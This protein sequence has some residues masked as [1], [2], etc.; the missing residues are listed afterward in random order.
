[1]PAHLCTFDVAQ[2][3]R[4]K[5]SCF[6][7]KTSSKRGIQSLDVHISCLY[8]LSLPLPIAIYDPVMLFEII[9]QRRRGSD[10][11]KAVA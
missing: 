10:Q 7:M 11:I 6:S 2:I 4:R 8:F 9:V 1:M 5:L 3:A